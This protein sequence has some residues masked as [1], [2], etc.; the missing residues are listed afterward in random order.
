MKTR[1]ALISLAVA[2]LASAAEMLTAHYW[3]KN[4]Y[5]APQPVELKLTASGESVRLSTRDGP[6]EEFGVTLTAKSSLAVGGQDA[7]S[8]LFGI[9]EMVRSRKPNEAVTTIGE[10]SNN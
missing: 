5:V 1:L 3:G 4:D 8:Q 6:L 7:Q 10:K 2:A 9:S